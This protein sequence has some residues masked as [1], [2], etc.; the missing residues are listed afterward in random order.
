VRTLTCRHPCPLPSPDVSDNDPILIE[1]ERRRALKGQAAAPRPAAPMLAA[2]H[3][4]LC[5]PAP[6]SPLT[7]KTKSPFRDAPVWNE[8]LASDSEAAVKS[9]RCSDK[10]I[11]ELQ[12]ETA[13]DF[14]VGPT[15]RDGGWGGC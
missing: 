3:G 4:E 2:H 7:G 15:L 9:E 14:E 13:H 1:R 12:E 5:Q 11:K 6:P 8:K 10:P